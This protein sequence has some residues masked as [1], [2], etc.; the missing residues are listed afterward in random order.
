MVGIESYSNLS[1][2][3]EDL[4]KKGFCFGQLAAIGLYAKM[5]QGINFKSSF[6]YPNA[7]ADAQ[8]SSSAYFHYKSSQLTFKEEFL[9]T[10][11]FKVMLELM[12]ASYKKFKGKVEGEI[13]G[14]TDAKKLTASVEYTSDKLKSKVAVTE[15]MLVKASVVGE[16]KPGKGLGVDLAFDSQAK[17]LTAYNTAFWWYEDNFRVVLKHISTD[18]KSYNFGNV[19]LSALYNWCSKLKLAAGVTY[20]KGGDSEVKLG[21]QYLAAD[22]SVFKARL[23][24]SANLAF[25]LRHKVCEKFTLVTAS[26][27][28]LGDPKAEFGFRLKINQ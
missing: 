9:S 27:F 10:N 12:P 4:V 8:N 28:N 17:R 23:D 16:I 19:G 21:L 24:Q 1:K 20:A 3:Q 18:K 13:N 7:S 15:E 25:S 6:K 2:Q 5:P 11:L 22:N 14:K 26:Q